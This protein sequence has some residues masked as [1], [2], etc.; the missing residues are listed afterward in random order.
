MKKVIYWVSYIYLIYSVFIAAWYAFDFSHPS[1]W[2]Y[3]MIIALTIGV[4]A[5]KGVQ[6]KTK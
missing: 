6:N 1:G 5:V 2:A 4:C 3:A